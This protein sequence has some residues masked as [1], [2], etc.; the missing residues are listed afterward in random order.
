MEMQIVTIENVRGYVDAKGTAYL[1]VED[2]ARGL[3]FTQVAKSGNEVVRWERV[4]RYLKEFGFIPTSGDDIKAGDY[5]P[6]N[7]FYLLAMKANNE[8]AKAFQTKIAEEILPSIR[9][10]GVYMTLEAAEKILYNP[11]FIIKLAQ[12]VKDLSAQVALLKPKADYCES[13]LQ[14]DG[15][16]P[17]TLIAKDYG[18]SAKAFNQLL[19][20]FKIQH[21]VGNAWVI[22]EPYSKMGYTK[23]IT[24]LKNGFSIMHTNW[25]QKGR[26]FLYTM[27]KKHGVLPTCERDD[28]SMNLF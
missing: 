15:N 7:I 4:N 14:S 10:T 24:T 16:I 5:I 23:S 12:Q 9:K 1:N 20:K 13:I 21:R 22:N 8:A 6:E 27:L 17:V 3:G 11:D 25:T 26:M 2:V 28:V 18:C 19:A